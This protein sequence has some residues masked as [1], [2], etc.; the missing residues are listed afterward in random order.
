[1]D[2]KEKILSTSFKLFINN[3]YHNTSMQQLVEASKMSKGAFYHYFKS[4]NDLYSQVIKQYFLSFYKE[5]DWEKYKQAELSIREI[6]QEIQNF[7]LSFIPKIM[8]LNEKGVSEYYVMYFEA[9]NLLP[10]FKKEV[11]KFYEN[12]T[13]VIINATDNNTEPIKI[14][15]KLIAK[16]EGIL[17]LL[18]IYPNRKINELIEQIAE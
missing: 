15:T 7:Y 12:L 1:M 11:Q 2:T 16:Y 10:E 5:V 8:A 6:E 13:T 4:K 14:A 18:A 17:F 3:G 9:F